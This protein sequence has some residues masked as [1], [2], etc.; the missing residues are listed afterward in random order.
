MAP[1]TEIRTLQKTGYKI[2]LIELRA[3]TLNLD[4]AAQNFKC[5]IFNHLA[6]WRE[7]IGSGIK[8]A[9]LKV[10]SHVIQA[11]ALVC[12]SSA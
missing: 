9:C 2:Q 3:T 10:V 11:Q 4:S 6:G 8:H 1:V 5:F 7:I 12:G